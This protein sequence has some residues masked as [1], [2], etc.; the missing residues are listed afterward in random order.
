MPIS[1]T[2][3]FGDKSRSIILDKIRDGFNPRVRAAVHRAGLLIEGQ[4][5]RNLSGPSHTKNPDNGNPFP[6]VVHGRLRASFNTQSA[7]SGYIETR[8]GTNL[9][10]A[11]IHEFGGMAGRGHKVRIPERPYIRPA[12]V[13]VGDKCVDMIERAAWQL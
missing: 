11:P 1:L 9:D 2:V 10:Y 8:V 7:Q 3:R 5:K 6:G 12:L 4:I 13:T